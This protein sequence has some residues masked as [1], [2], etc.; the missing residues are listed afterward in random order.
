M[1][2]HDTPDD[3]PRLIEVALTPV[4]PLSGVGALLN[5]FTGRLARAAVRRSAPN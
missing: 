5:V 3:A 2:G 4:F 1:L